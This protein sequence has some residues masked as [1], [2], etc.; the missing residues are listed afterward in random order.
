MSDL[1]EAKCVRR[2][3]IRSRSTSLDSA[4][5]NEAKEQ[6][7]HKLD[8]AYKDALSKQ[9]THNVHA[10]DGSPSEIPCSQEEEAYEFQ[11]FSQRSRPSTISAPQPSKVLLRSPSPEAKEPGFVRPARSQNFYL[12]GPVTTEARKRFQ[13]AAIE[14][15]HVMRQSQ[16]MWPGSWVPWRLNTFTLPAYKRVNTHPRLL[17]TSRGGKR[18]RPGK[19][20]RLAVR[21]KIQT[22]KKREEVVRLAEADKAAFHAEKRSRRNREKQLKRRE[23]ARNQK[24]AQAEVTG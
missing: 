7:R 21:T 17:E 19:K 4:S 11:L 2:S 12:T 23:K 5:S 8:L 9:L 13:E 10:P 18:K 15:Q 16:T 22:R 20:R 6:W 1:Q 24:K 14:G 3:E